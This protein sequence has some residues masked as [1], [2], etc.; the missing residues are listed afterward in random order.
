MPPKA[1]N[2]IIIGAGVA[3]AA[4]A[5]GLTRRGENNILIIERDPIP[6]SRASGRNASLIRRNL[7]TSNDC[8]M[9]LEGAHWFEH[10]P[11]GFPGN[12]NWR[13]TGS[14]MLFRERER[15]RIAREFA[16]QRA[17]SVEFD[18]ISPARAAA[19]QP[20][21]QQSAF[22][23]AQWVPGDGII[24]I[25][26]LLH[27]YLR[28]A[29]TAGAT[30]QTG[31]AVSS[32]IFEG[33]RVAGVRAEG[34]E[35]RAGTT[36][37]AAGGWANYLLSDLAP[38]LAMTPCRRTMLVTEPSGIVTEPAGGG[39]H[40]SNAAPRPFTW[41]DGLGFYFREDN[42]GLL[43]SPCDE[44][45]SPECHETVDPAWVARARERAGKLI[46]AAAALRIA[47]AWGCLRTLT[48]DREMFIGFDREVPGLFWVAGLGGH[49][50]TNSPTIAEIASDLLIH[51]RT[52][53]IDMKQID[54]RRHAAAGPG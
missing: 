45:P 2:Y 19:L 26:E 33:G 43:W 10:P 40:A 24:D 7:K 31:V 37:N 54:P 34:R 39:Q 16:V 28:A 8:R 53:L 11:A 14:L 1:W 13:R 12:V 38:P 41:D 32:F 17:S 29:V 49:G 42:G 18:E 5:Y 35:L 52:E 21:L 51:G 27:G 30:L 3:G 23:A 47:F 6:G 50:V 9:A 36:I 22:D 20:L 46:P 4:T 25:V 44:E 15:P 48:F